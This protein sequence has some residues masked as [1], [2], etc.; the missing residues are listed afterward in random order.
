MKTRTTSILLAGGLLLSAC[1][2]L[3]LDTTRCVEIEG[4]RAVTMTLGPATGN[5]SLEMLPGSY[6]R[7]GFCP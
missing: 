3:N 7:R 1:A 2:L 5:S 4:S 6:Y